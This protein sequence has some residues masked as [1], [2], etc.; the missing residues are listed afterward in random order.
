[1]VDLLVKYALSSP[2][3]AMH[4][5]ISGSEAR[6]ETMTVHLK[7]SEVC[8]AFTDARGKDETCARIRNRARRQQAIYPNSTSGPFMCSSYISATI[9]GVGARVCSVEII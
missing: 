6:V 7:S 1:M 5:C 8:K 9:P 2:A 3:T 4:T